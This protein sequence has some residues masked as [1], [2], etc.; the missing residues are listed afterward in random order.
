MASYIEVNYGRERAFFGQPN[1]IFPLPDQF[2]AL[3]H[4]LI[5]FLHLEFARTN[6]IFK[7][8]SARERGYGIVQTKGGE[9]NAD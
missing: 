7:R 9:D 5:F 2:G 4:V 1:L 6:H 3:R 8:K